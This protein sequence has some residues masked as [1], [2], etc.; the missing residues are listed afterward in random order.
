LRANNID[1]RVVDAGEDA[2]RLVLEV[3]PEG[4]ETLSGVTSVRNEGGSRVIDS[5]CGRS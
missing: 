3:I 1:A 5:K 2:R 4:N